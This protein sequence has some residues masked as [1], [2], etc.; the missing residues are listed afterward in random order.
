MINKELDKECFKLYKNKKYYDETV[1]EEFFNQ[2]E[3]Y[4]YIHKSFPGCGMKIYIKYSSSF[5]SYYL[6]GDFYCF[7]IIEL[8]AESR[9]LD[10]YLINY[11]KD[12]NFRT[13]NLF[14]T[15]QEMF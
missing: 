6:T 9:K 4:Q 2:K 12:K 15:L 3:G 13:T 1:K 8:F 11:C 10:N 14:T 5:F 7:S